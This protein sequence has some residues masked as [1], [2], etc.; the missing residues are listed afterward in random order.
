MNTNLAMLIIGSVLIIIGLIKNLIPVK[1]N[2]SIFG[3][4]EGKAENYAAAMRT[5]IGAL[6]IGMGI[7]LLMNRNDYDSNQLLLSIGI[8]L[9]IFLLSIILGYIRKFMDHIPIPPMIII[10]VLIVISFTSSL[11]N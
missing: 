1:F 5:N 7:V 11:A 6:L 9:S 10:G 8:A 2:E 4:I 3:K